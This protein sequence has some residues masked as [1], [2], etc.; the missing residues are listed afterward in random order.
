[1]RISPEEAAEPGRLE[2]LKMSARFL[3]SAERAAIA[4]DVRQRVAAKTIK[5]GK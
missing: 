2:R 4:E 5:A 1:V 3:S